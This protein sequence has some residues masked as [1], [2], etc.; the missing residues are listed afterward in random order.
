MKKRKQIQTLLW[1]PSPPF[2]RPFSGWTWFSQSSLVWFQ[3]STFV[4]EEN[5]KEVAGVFL[6][7]RCRSCQPDNVVKALKKAQNNGLASFCLHRPPVLQCIQ[8]YIVEQ[9]VTSDTGLLNML[10]TTHY[11]LPGATSDRKYS[12]WPSAENIFVQAALT[13]LALR[14]E[15]S[16]FLFQHVQLCYLFLE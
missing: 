11:K 10:Q 2:K 1:R 13:A 9:C 4:S 3:R 14:P 16:K 15:A 8:A 6:M 12:S 5:C 7:S